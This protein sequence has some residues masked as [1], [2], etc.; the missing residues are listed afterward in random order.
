MRRDRLQAE[1][2]DLR[3]GSFQD[4]PPE[5]AGRGIVPFTV[6]RNLIL[7]T[8]L[9]VEDYYLYGRMLVRCFLDEVAYG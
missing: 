4:G 9:E 7:F 3:R 1:L 6:A 8:R 2:E 5:N